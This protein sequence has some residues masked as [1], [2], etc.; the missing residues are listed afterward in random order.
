MTS[1]F[2]I[3]NLN[4]PPGITSRDAVNVVQRLVRPAKVGHAGTLD[5]MASGV[6]LICVGPA[7]RLISLIQQAPKTYLAEF[8][9][10]HTSDTDDSTGK[11][12]PVDFVCRP[13]RE[14]VDDALVKY[15][16][17]IEQVPP[18]YSAVKVKGQRSYKLARDGQAVELRAKT[19]TIHEIKVLNYDWPTL[20]LSIECGSGTYIRSLARDLGKDLGVG[21]LMS[22]L[23]RTR[24]G[25][26]S[27]ADG[28]CPD[29]INAESLPDALQ[30][31][32][33][34][35]GRLPQYLCSPQDEIEILAGRRV[36]VDSARMKQ[37]DGTT[38]ALVD[39]AQAS[40]LALAEFA[41]KKSLQPRQ[42][43]AV[44]RPSS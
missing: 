8:K 21:G 31:P 44:A 32:I 10:G 29:D 16:G 28:I 7:T 5:P 6:L 37:G 27:V 36:S 24:I 35:V 40:L 33:R 41:G 39:Q 3:L 20:T 25:Q 17:E 19:V 1:P 38:V 15:G 2:G 12:T 23:Q 13:T 4:K 34:V 18:D 14:D 22:D 30:N 26:F 42:V 11:L 9:F 43:F